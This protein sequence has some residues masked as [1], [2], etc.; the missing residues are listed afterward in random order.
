MVVV[1]N[2]ATTTA[3]PQWAVRDWVGAGPVSASLGEQGRVIILFWAS[4][5]P[6][7]KGKREWG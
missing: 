2:P 5:S 1:S 7:S 4:V 3:P 6:P